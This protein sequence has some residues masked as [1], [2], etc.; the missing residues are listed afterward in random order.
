MSDIIEIEPDRVR[1]LIHRDRDP[2]HFAR[3]KATIK[4]HGQIL[5]GQVRDL[6]HLAPRERKRPDGGHYD[7][8]LI[9]GQGR[10]EIAADLGRKFRATVEKKSEAATLGMFM[11]ENIVRAPLPS[12]EMG[13]LVKAETDAGASVEEAADALMIEPSL[14]RRLLAVVNKTAIGLEDDVA[15]MT[16]TDA[17]LLTGLPDTHQSIVM[18][19]LKE[20]GSRDLRAVVRRAKDAAKTGPLSAT[21]L[22][23][24]IDGLQK[25]AKELRESLGLARLHHSIGPLNLQMLLADK[26]FRKA[27]AEEGIHFKKFE[28]VATA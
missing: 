11:S 6:R 4:R 21:D 24:S 14:A 10:L 9:T 23:A 16:L 15:E 1:V 2:A 5:P 20:S 17:E 22:K 7:F 13:K 26:K 25:R 27:A 19:V 28:T 3:V 18:S 8:E 12:F